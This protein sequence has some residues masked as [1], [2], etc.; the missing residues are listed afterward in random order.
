MRNLS[1]YRKPLLWLVLLLP[2]LLI[3][4]QIWRD[5]LGADPAERLSHL[6]GEW[7][8]RILLLTLFL[9][10]VARRFQGARN[11]LALRRMCGLF[12]FFY[13]SLHL[14]VFLAMYLGFD[15][16]VLKDEFLKRPYIVAGTLAWLLLIP[17]AATSFNA[18]IRQL[19]AQRWKALHR[20]V[21]VALL[22]VVVHLAWQV[23]SSWEDA[24]VYGTL[25]LMLLLERFF[26]GSGAKYK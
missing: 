22:L 14:L 23:R 11:L 12:A 25:S 13:A 15:P 4:W 6:T 24:A 20:M 1:N 17:L 2:L 21:Y 18:A 5:Q 7:S 8:L 19:G 3:A 26:V 9:S 10:V 16:A